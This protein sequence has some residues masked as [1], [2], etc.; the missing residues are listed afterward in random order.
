M[1]ELKNGVPASI[2]AA[3]IEM[4][5]KSGERQKAMIVDLLLQD[6]PIVKTILGKLGSHFGDGFVHNQQPAVFCV[7]QYAVNEYAATFEYEAAKTP[8][9]ERLAAFVNALVTRGSQLLPE[10]VVECQTGQSW[11]VSDKQCFHVWLQQVSGGKPCAAG[12]I[13]VYQAQNP[14]QQILLAT[15]IYNSLIDPQTNNL[16]LKA[17]GNQS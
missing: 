11:R 8:D 3:E 17:R 10:L 4:A 5:V 1:I 13:K 9:I 12:S 15:Q 16:L 14:H 2:K 6:W 7:A